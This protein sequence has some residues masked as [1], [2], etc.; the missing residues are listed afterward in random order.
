MRSSTE[1]YTGSDLKSMA[2][3]KESAFTEQTA[4]ALSIVNMIDTLFRESKL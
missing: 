2:G 3:V 1:K 4:K